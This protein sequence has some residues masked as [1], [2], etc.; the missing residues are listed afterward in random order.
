MNAP[1]FKLPPPALLRSLA[2]DR[3]YGSAARR[4]TLS[5]S[6]R[7]RVHARPVARPGPVTGYDGYKAFQEDEDGGEKRVERR[8]EMEATVVRRDATMRSE[9]S[10]KHL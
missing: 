4:L 7:V 9:A 8:A 1:G 5:D 6:D 3:P 10:L 2:P